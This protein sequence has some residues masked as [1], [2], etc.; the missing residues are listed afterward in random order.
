MLEPLGDMASYLLTKTHDVTP[1]LK[2]FVEPPALLL[3]C[4][5]GLANTDAATE[6]S[7]RCE[8][9]EINGMIAFYNPDVK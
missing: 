9:V 2:G 8:K 4:R 7:H 5:H 6:V 3:Q 1:G